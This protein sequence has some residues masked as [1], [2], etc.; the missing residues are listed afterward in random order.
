M[1][2]ESVDKS[3][4]REGVSTCREEVVLISW[5]GANQTPPDLDNLLLNF[6]VRRLAPGGGRHGSQP[7]EVMEIC[8]PVLRHGQFRE[9]MHPGWELVRG[10]TLT[11]GCEHPGLCEGERFNEGVDEI[12]LGLHNTHGRSRQGSAQNFTNLLQTNFPVLPSIVFRQKVRSIKFLP[13]HDLNHIIDSPSPVQHLLILTPTA[14]ITR[15][16]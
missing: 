11:G 4:S 10:E 2:P 12:S 1:L 14:N 8:L 6:S 13:P 9:K 7:S 3:Q 16:Q 15:S 5:G